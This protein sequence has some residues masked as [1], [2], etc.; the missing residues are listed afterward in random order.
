MIGLDTNVLVRMF[1][2]DDKRQRDAAASLLEGL[3]GG[4]K[5]F[6]NAVVL[7]ELVWTLRRVYKFNRYQISAVLRKLSEHPKILLWDRDIVRDAAHLHLE[8]G[9]DVSD[10]VIALMN[11]AAGCS[12]TY[13]FDEEASSSR[14]FALIGK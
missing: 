7:A 5:A 12:V 8:E 4:Q 3:K 2:E 10:C 1:A 6:V 9:S 11:I 14:G 13:T